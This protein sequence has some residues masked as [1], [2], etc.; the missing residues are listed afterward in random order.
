MRNDR[1]ILEEIVAAAMV[2]MEVGVHD[3]VDVAGSEPNEGQTG[4]ERVLG[5]HDW[6][7]HLHQCAP[8]LF[9]MIDD[10]RVAPG[11]E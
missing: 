6:R 7:H 5:A 9:A 10:R 3:H 4:E 2:R 1:R 8:A 11:I